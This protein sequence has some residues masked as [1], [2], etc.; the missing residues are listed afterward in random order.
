M[1]LHDPA[2]DLRSRDLGRGIQEIA[3][4][5]PDEACRLLAVIELLLQQRGWLGLG[6]CLSSVQPQFG[7]HM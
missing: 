5:R 3:E 1:D 7:F 6:R 4:V 2:G